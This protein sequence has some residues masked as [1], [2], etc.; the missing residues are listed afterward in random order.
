M[1]IFFLPLVPFLNFLFFIFRA[2]PVA[3][4][5]SQA[6]G[7]IGTAPWAYTTTTATRDPSRIWELCHSLWQC[8]IL[9]PLSEAR[10]PTRILMDTSWIPNPWNHNRNSRARSLCDMLSE[11]DSSLSRCMLEFFFY[12]F[13][14]TA[15][16]WAPQWQ[17]TWLNIPPLS[18]V[19][20]TTSDG[21]HIVPFFLLR[22][23]YL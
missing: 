3:Y 12:L 4:G 13:V 2:T 10:D 5:S 14:F 21:E 1:N 11:Q 18:S 15:R 19:I 6:R 7:Q 22:Q 20:F 8:Q 9:N 23:L 17:Y 16:P